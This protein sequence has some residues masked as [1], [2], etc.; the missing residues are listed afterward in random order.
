MQLRI[1]VLLAACVWAAPGQSRRDLPPPIGEPALG[2]RGAIATGSGFAAEAGLRLYHQGGN[3]VDA[4]VAAT[5]AAAIAEYS[6]F[7]FGGECPIL[8][9]AAD[10]QVHSIA[11]VGAM[12]KLASA[13]LFRNRRL[14]PGEVRRVEPGGVKHFIPVA[15]PMP[16]LVPG[17]VD[18]ALVAL[19]E[20]GVK[21]AADVLEPAAQLA[22]GMPLDETRAGSIARGV[23]Y[24]ELW[25]DS[26]R[27]FLPGGRL[28]G[29]GDVFR[30]PGLARTIRAMADVERRA[31]AA[32]RGRAE[33]ID[34]VRDCFY[35][36]EIARRIGD[37]C[38]QHGALLRYEDMAAFRLQ[39]EAPAAT[40]Y[41]GATVYKPGF[42]SQGPVLLQVLNLL[43]GFDLAAMGYNTSGYLHHL[44]ESIKLA[45]A[46]RDAYYA[47]PAFASVPARRLLSKEYARERRALV[48][49]AA[50]LDFRPGAIGEA[51]P[52]H[53]SAYD[54]ERVEIDEALKARD[55][56]CVNAV[57]S[58]GVM[59]S[60][61]PSG[62]W[63]PSWIAGDTGIPLTQRAQS[64]NL[65]EGHPNEIAG[66]KRPR[67]TLSPTIVTRDGRPFLALSTPG[68]DNQDQ[69]LLQLLLNV[70]EF[71]MSTQMAVEA[72]RVQSRHLVSSFDNHAMHPGELR[73]D[74]RIPEAVLEQ[75]RR[76]GHRLRVHSR[77][78]SGAAP[79]MI[80]TLPGGVI[81]A[82]ADPY[83]SRVAW[84]W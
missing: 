9:R 52:R 63:M 65:L 72:P 15:G 17:M 25:P 77:W 70:I 83:G 14:Q 4:G 56:T 5:F 8:V 48:G 64:F 32:G 78:S 59:F 47:D 23:E 60:A 84:A 21:S 81:E 46:D 57:D 12:P 49:A 16:A 11:G 3:A 69:A 31:L 6:H 30:Q 80:Q 74:E 28:P 54:V 36:G 24:F 27:V 67:I 18:A 7:G 38:R 37:F 62:A 35:R 33:A 71:G 2:L 68:G 1:W 41:R 19:R 26:W 42:W 10:G 44:A 76:R 43:E 79:V 53:P 22:A 55:T 58:A 34:A 13:E 73:A 51:P 39:P 82:A 40:E 20:F 75:L 29:P 66:G 50:S 61:T 45:Y